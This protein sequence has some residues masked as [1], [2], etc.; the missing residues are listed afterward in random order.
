VKARG[1]RRRQHWVLTANAV[2]QC[3]Q[4]RSPKLAH[5]ACKVCGTYRGRTVIAIADDAKKDA[6]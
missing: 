1:L 2:V 3:D 4:C 5:A 6:A